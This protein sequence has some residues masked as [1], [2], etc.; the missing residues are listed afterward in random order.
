MGTYYYIYHYMK[1]CFVQFSFSGVYEVNFSVTTMPFKTQSLQYL[2]F[3]IVYYILL[4]SVWF[5]GHSVTK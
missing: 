5:D 3:M 4:L 1:V 2:S